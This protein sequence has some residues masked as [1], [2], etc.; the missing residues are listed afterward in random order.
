MFD[1]EE[2]IANVDGARH[3]AAVYIKD[4]VPVR[5]VHEDSAYDG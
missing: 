5:A 3:Y 4:K 2:A 1:F